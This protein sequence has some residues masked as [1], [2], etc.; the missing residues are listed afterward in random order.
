MRLRGPLVQNLPTIA[1]STLS[2]NTWVIFNESRYIL[3]SVILSRNIGNLYNVLFLDLE[4][5]GSVCLGFKSCVSETLHTSRAL[6]TNSF[7]F[8]SSVWKGKHANRRPDIMAN[9][10]RKS[11]YTHLPPR[12]DGQKPIHRL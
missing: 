4:N 11:I 10:F 9:I 5:V 6:F 7:F 1:F 2:E 12:I 8:F 3:Y